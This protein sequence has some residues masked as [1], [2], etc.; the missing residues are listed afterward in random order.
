MGKA[1]DMTGFQSLALTVTWIWLVAVAVRFRRS[2][3][4]LLAG[5]VG[6]GLLALAARGRS[7]VHLAERVGFEPTVDLRLRQFSRLVP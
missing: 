1:H 4:F 2:M 7:S 6:I 3:T 5:L